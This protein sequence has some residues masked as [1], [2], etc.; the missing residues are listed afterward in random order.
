M[1]KSIENTLRELDRIRNQEKELNRRKDDLHQE[2]YYLW[3]KIGTEFI[4][5]SRYP[6][7]YDRVHFSLIARIIKYKSEGIDFKI[8]YSKELKET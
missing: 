6:I 4:I 3:Y 2:Y 8:T 1:E 5:D 7:K